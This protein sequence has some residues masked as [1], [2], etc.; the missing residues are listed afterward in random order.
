MRIFYM[1][2][3]SAKACNRRTIFAINLSWIAFF[4]YWF[5]FIKRCYLFLTLHLLQTWFVISILILVLL[6]LIDK[7]NISSYNPSCP[8]SVSSTGNSNLSIRLSAKLQLWLSSLSFVKSCH[9]FS[10]YPL[11]YV[12]LSY[13]YCFSYHFFLNHI[14]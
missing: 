9:S 13:I 8:A 3:L 2:P 1:T 14:Q 10:L 12:L 6:K 4:T 7:F 5:L 11:L